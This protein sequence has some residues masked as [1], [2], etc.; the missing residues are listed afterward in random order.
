MPFTFDP[1]APGNWELIH[2]SFRTVQQ[3]PNAERGYIPI[4]PADL[5]EIFTSPVIA[6]SAG[7]TQAR[8]T[9]WLGCNLFQQVDI[10]GLTEFQSEQI[11]VPINRPPTIFTMPIAVPQY[12]LYVEVPYW[13]TQLNLSIW[14]YTGQL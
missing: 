10:T 6:V 3:A 8:G 12:Q 9:W 11:S 1:D 13:H 14:Q 2:N 5:P 7:N 4:P